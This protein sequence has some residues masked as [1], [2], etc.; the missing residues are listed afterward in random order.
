M[1][2]KVLNVKVTSKCLQIRLPKTYH[3]VC[4]ENTQSTWVYGKTYDFRTIKGPKV[5]ESVS[6]QIRVL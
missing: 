6:E 2:L 4:S 1:I 5:K 3:P